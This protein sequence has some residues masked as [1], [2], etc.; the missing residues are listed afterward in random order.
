LIREKNYIDKIEMKLG[1]SSYSFT[2]AVGVKGNYPAKRL[3]E[4]DLL[5]LANELNVG[6]VQIADNMPL[7]K[8]PEERFVNLLKKANE[9]HIVLETG[10]NVMTESNLERYILLAEKM[11]SRIL[12]FAIDGKDYHPGVSEIIP[13][14]MNA[15]QEL[16]SRNI[17][18]ALENHDRLFASDFIN[19]V[20]KV[21]SPHV[22]LC[23]D[24]A[25]SLGLGEGFHE[26]VKELAPYTVNFH[27]K[28]VYIKRKYHMMG[29]DVEGRPFGEGCLPLEWMLEQLPP[30]CKTAILEQWTPPE[31]SIEKTIEKERVWAEKSLSYLSKYFD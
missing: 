13:I 23:L 1:I 25:N 16:K 11:G 12:R 6:L 21:G 3:T 26:V 18:L 29:F 7:H 10:A 14:I 8:M 24:C 31:E 30:K 27:L 9:Y 20:E 17:V 15:E 28:E 19:I 4:L 2:W 22:G 5:D